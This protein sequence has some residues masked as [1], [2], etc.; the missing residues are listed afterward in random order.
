MTIKNPIRKDRKPLQ[1]LLPLQQ[2]LRVCIDPCDICNFKCEFCFQS[3]DVNFKG[4]IMAEETFMEVVKQL[5]EFESPINIVHLYGLGEPLINQH[6]PDFIE[7]LKREGVAKEVAITTNGSLLKRELSKKMIDAGLDRLSI[8]LNGINNEQFEK[9]VKAKV[10]F[11]NIYSQIKWFYLNRQQCHLHV[12]ING[13][14]FTKEEQKRFVDLF[15]NITDTINIDHVV[16][17]WPGLE[18][19]QEKSEKRT[20]YD[21]DTSLQFAGQ[22]ICSEMFYEVVIHSDGTVSPCGVD[23]GYHKENLGNIFDM[24][25][26]DI[27]NSKK[28]EEMLLSNL[29]GGQISYSPCNNCKLPYCAQTVNL[30]QYREELLVRMMKKR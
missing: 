1:E 11:D 29:R 23:H 7:I 9:L 19:I 15:E 8:S 4:T 30:E 21:M 18:V 26:K 25:L 16:N 13:E 24:P 22:A 27:W 12:K 17:V 6:I 5:K 3:H 10:D 28:R 14:C 20:L 2:P